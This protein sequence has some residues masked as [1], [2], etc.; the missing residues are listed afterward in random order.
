ME[1]ILQCVTQ[2]CL[3]WREKAQRSIGRKNRGKERREKFQDINFSWKTLSEW[4]LV[5]YVVDG[6]R[7]LLT[8]RK[9]H[10]KQK[11]P[12]EDSGSSC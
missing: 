10:N 11:E 2:V 3:H 1:R 5:G 6:G 12:E 9:H 7:G 8:G 4:L